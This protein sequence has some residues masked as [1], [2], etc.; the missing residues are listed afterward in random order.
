MR[1][2]IPAINK[3]LPESVT[4]MSMTTSDPAQS[5]ISHLSGLNGDKV[6][7][8]PVVIAVATSVVTAE[9]G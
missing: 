3:S 4:D 5:M 6:Q 2:E 8:S 1:V 7:N 9:F